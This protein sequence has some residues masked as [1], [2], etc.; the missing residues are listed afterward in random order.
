MDGLTDPTAGAGRRLN[1]PEFSKHRC[2]A[3]EMGISITD[4]A[5][6]ELTISGITRMFEG[7][8]G[9]ESRRPKFFPIHQLL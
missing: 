8:T 1:L 6:L 5:S 9:C 7:R 2:P 3:T 4:T